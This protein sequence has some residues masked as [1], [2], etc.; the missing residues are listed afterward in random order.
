MTSPSRLVEGR[1]TGV[2]PVPSALA[3]L[4]LVGFTLCRYRAAPREGGLTE[5]IGCGS[6]AVTERSERTAQGYRRFRCRDRGKQ[7]NERSAG[8]LMF[9][10][11]K[12]SSHRHWL[13][14]CGDAGAARRAGAGTSTRPTS[15]P[16]GGGVISTVPSTARERRS[17]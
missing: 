13:K 10:T 14:A 16:T 7:F 15:R 1:R 4:D 3:P 12:P 5:C 8:S 9:A 2:R 6:A 11:G 17:T